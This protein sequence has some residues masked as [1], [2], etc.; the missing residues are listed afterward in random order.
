MRALAIL[1]LLA[2]LFASF[3]PASAAAQ[4][5]RVVV[6]PGLEVGDLHALEDRGAVGLL[7]PGA[8][9]ETSARSAQAALER[10]AV[11]N[12]LR[13]GLPPGPTLITVETG[14]VPRT[15]P[16]IV[17]ALPR[18]G[19]Q[20]NDRRYPVAVLA[21]GYR[22]LLTSDSTRI[23]GLVS[24]ADVAPTALGRADE[25]GSNPDTRPTDELERLDERIDDNNDARKTLTR[26]VAALILMLALVAP[27]AAV[28]GVALVLVGNLVLGAVAVDS[29]ALLIVAVGLSVLAGAALARVVRS[30]AAV[31]AVLA[32]TLAA[33]LAAFLADERWVALSPLGPTQNARF[34]GLS[35][36]LATLLLVPALAGGALL[37][38]Q[39]LALLAPVAM[40]AFVVVAGNR[41]GA[42][43]GGAIVLAVGF[44]V[45]TASLAGLGRRALALAVGG[46]L[47][48]AVAAIGLEAALGASSHITRALEGGPGGLAADLRDRL[49]LSF[50]HATAHWQNTTIVVVG[51]AALALLGARLLRS[52]LPL[53]ER[54]LPLAFLA[55]IAT[56]LVV[57][58]S[59]VEV[60]MT[61]LACYVAVL[62]ASPGGSSAAL[63][64]P[65]SRAAR[66][67]G[68]SA[69]VS[70]R[71]PSRSP[72]PRPGP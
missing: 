27:R 18:G 46:A 4:A 65:P 57:N 3:A 56:S 67:F 14:R 2:A 44:A 34:Y 29:Q 60:A 26:L 42:D 66:S 32:G 58:D 40:L 28:L 6:V 68:P 55:A 64:R 11:R 59:P 25:L 47:V 38:R 12:S 71:A 36:L 1:G 61:G 13:G 19:D 30:P 33:Y 41:F 16:A 10:G 23:P 43:G 45:L 31:G 39:R 70:R 62:R 50:A 69:C 51:V 24:V 9:P 17:L 48:L 8:G 54:A 72:S 49:S 37:A 5:F 63:A 15:G 20:P 21:P 35:N 7:V 22:G 52:P 53:A